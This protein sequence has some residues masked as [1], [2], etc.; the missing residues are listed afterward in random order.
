MTATIHYTS[1]PVCNSSRISRR[2]EV[3]DHSVSGEIFEVWECADCTLRFTQDIPPSSEIGR[4]YQSDNY[5]SHSDTA[6]GIV[7]KLYHIVRKRTLLSKKA[8]VTRFSQ[9]STGTLLDIGAGT[10]AFAGVM[11]EAG[12]Q[13][14]ALEPDPA[15]RELA[16]K[17]H[18]IQ[19]YDPS[20][21]FDLNADSIEV[22]TMWHV[23]EHVHTLHEYFTQFKKIV[24]SGGILLIAVP[25]YTS[26]DASKYGTYWAAYDVPRHLYHFSPKAMQTLLNLHELQLEKLLPM[27]YD[28]FYVSMLSEKYKTGKQQLGKGVLTG[29]QSNWKAMHQKNR[30]SSLVYV[31]KIP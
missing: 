6:Q 20:F 10:G 12:W 8:L 17:S 24:K 4:Y 2:F 28:S 29:I 21:L 27:W 22:I 23:L 5:I 18:H 1:C 25:N 30:C 14:T 11:R 13:I 9:K 31:V 3:K 19:M 26:F 15:A 16:A 7:N